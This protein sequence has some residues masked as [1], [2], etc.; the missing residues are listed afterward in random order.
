M[1][2]GFGVLRCGY[3]CGVQITSVAVVS[4]DLRCGWLPLGSN[5]REDF[6]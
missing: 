1:V 2:V 4:L 5:N 6:S 3:R